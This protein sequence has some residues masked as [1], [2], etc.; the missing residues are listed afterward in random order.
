M[1][2]DNVVL[3]AIGSYFVASLPAAKLLATRPVELRGGFVSAQ[4]QDSGFERGARFTPVLVL[5]LQRRLGSEPGRT[6][7][8]D[9][10]RLGLVTVLAPGPGVA[11]DANVDVLVTK[12]DS[13]GA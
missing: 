10:R 2:G 8:H 4:R 7:R 3:D 13:A 11:R 12:R 9:H 5:A 1:V 6:M